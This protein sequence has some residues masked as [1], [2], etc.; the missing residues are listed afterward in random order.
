MKSSVLIHTKECSFLKHLNPQQC[1]LHPLSK[2]ASV[3]NSRG[4][5]LKHF[6]D[7]IDFIQLRCNIYVECYGAHIAQFSLDENFSENIDRILD[8]IPSPEN[9][10]SDFVR[11]SGVD[12]NTVKV[13]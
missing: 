9:T 3:S 11:L 10:K 6:Y 12:L 1:P 13:L 5:I 7:Y 4:H 8:S 2:F